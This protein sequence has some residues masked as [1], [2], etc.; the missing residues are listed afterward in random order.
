MENQ[1][2]VVMWEVFVSAVVGSQSLM[3]GCGGAWPPTIVAISRRLL[4][5]LI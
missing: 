3:G 4:L 5:D 2:W 1:S